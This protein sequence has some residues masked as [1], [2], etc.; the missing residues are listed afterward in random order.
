[1]VDFDELSLKAMYLFEGD[2][3]DK[4]I[5]AGFF[6]WD[7]DEFKEELIKTLGEGYSQ[8]VNNQ[9]EKNK[10]DNDYRRK[11][12]EVFSLISDNDKLKIFLNPYFGKLLSHE[13]F[14]KAFKGVDPET[15]IKI[16]EDKEYIL[17]EFE[18]KMYRIVDIILSLNDLDMI[19]KYME[20]YTKNDFYF[21][22]EKAISKLG[23]D[24]IIEF[25]TNYD[26]YIRFNDIFKSYI[27]KKAPIEIQERFLQNIDNI[28][29]MTERDK[30]EFVVLMDPKLKEKY[31]DKD[32][33]KRYKDV[34]VDYE[35]VVIEEA[36]DLNIYKNLDRLIHI[37]PPK[38][39]EEEKFNE[40]VKICPK[41]KIRV[42]KDC[43]LHIGA[44]SVE[45]YT[46]AKNWID[47]VVK[48]IN[49]EYSVLQKVAMVLHAMGKRLSYSSTYHTENFSEGKTRNVWKIISSGEGVCNGF[50]AV[51]NHILNKLGV[52]SQE[53]GSECHAYLLVNNCEKINSNNNEI[54]KGDMLFDPTGDMCRYRYD[55]LPKYFGIS[56]DDIRKE[57]IEDGVD[58]LVHKNQEIED[59]KDTILELN[60]QEKRDL[61]YSVG[62]IDE[63]RKFK[64]DGIDDRLKK[65]DEEYSYDIKLNIKKRIEILKEYQPKFLSCFNSSKAFIKLYL[66]YKDN[67][68][69]KKCIVSRVYLKEDE[70]KKPRMYINVETEDGKELYYISKVIDDKTDDFVEISKEEFLSKY[71]FFEEDLKENNK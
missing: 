21:E 64:S 35:N 69:C 19:C 5:Y 54:Q 14:Y 37:Y 41:L 51:A 55:F 10:S 2:I 29:C 62:I 20:K 6:N 8:E 34:K 65:I 12:E 15:K 30:A 40:L 1:M 11:I 33:V 48:S 57:D 16:I 36:K 45:D 46:I 39:S 28:T 67:F 38:E 24:K 3:D 26:E 71:D 17:K 68:T 22:I 66:F 9:L 52:S 58:L 13:E 32:L 31:K 25:F 18:N 42:E 53:I 63:S 4:N 56:Y 49:P 50:V 44:S 27:L 60:E 47:E 59:R 7:Y 23:Y 70:D 61:F 43:T